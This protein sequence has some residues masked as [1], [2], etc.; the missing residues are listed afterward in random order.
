VR[1]TPKV[2]LNEEKT[3]IIDFSQPQA[4]VEFLGYR[5]YR[6]KQ[7]NIRRL[8]SRK[9]NKKFRDKIRAI[10]SRVSGRSF[11]VIIST[12]NKYLRGWLSYFKH[13]SKVVM[14]DEDAFIRRRLRTMLR[15]RSKRKGQSKGFDHF[16]WT[17]S[18]L[19][20]QGYHALTVLRPRC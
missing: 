12:L 13:C 3:K 2:G 8:V 6:N 16:V 1:W 4:S 10:T 20:K 19:A 7:G 9:S 15:K 17:N 11:A 5:F 14:K 18:Y